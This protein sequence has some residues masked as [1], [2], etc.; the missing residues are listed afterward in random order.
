MKLLKILGIFLAV[1]VAMQ[2][3]PVDRTNPP[4]Q[5]NEDFVKIMQTPKKVETLLKNACYDCH[6][7]ETR[8]P[9]YAYF[10]PIS[11]S[12]KHH[13]NE[14]R[15]HGN[16]ST[17]AKYSKEAQIHFLENSVKQIQD[18]KMPLPG[19]IAQ[20]PEANIS[21]AERKLLTNY[22]EQVLKERMHK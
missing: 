5:E 8:Y 7:N 4:V 11:W 2:L 10:A 21:D 3:V 1:L 6:S 9:S 20:H 12:V 22:F 14:G 17:W 19:Y 13:I 18:K 15:E 16:L